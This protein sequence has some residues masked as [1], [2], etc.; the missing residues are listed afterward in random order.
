MSGLDVSPLAIG[1]AKTFIE[2]GQETFLVGLAGVEI[3]SGTSIS[4]IKVRG[5]HT[6][7]RMRSQLGGR[8]CGG[9]RGPEHQHGVKCVQC[10]MTVLGIDGTRSETKGVVKLN[11]E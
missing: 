5:V 8:E 1:D 7:C 2:S 11:D 3:S 4:Q 10:W 6:A 9:S